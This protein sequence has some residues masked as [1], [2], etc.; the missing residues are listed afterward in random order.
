MANLAVPC[1][2]E[3]PKNL[4]RM[5]TRTTAG[6]QTGGGRV[7][8]AGC[9]K[10]SRLIT[11][12]QQL[13]LSWIKSSHSKQPKPCSVWRD[14]YFAKMPA[15]GGASSGHDWFFVEEQPDGSGVSLGIADGVG[16]WEESGID[17]SHFSQALM[18][19]ASE[20][21]RRGGSTR[22]KDLLSIAHDAVLA[23]KGVIAG[24]FSLPLSAPS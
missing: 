4:K 1:S 13:F 19:F 12:V 22:P 11:Y 14:A 17:P 5:A 3:Q 9:S 16:G 15:P 24:E 23:E 18:W 2:E 21:V 20:E 6:D 7:R 10:D 8:R